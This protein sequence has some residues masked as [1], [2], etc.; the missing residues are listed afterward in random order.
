MGVTLGVTS[1]L[2]VRLAVGLG[3]GV[4][5]GGDGVWLAVKALKPRKRIRKLTNKNVVFFKVGT[6]HDLKQAPAMTSVSRRK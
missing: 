1:P 5:V 4:G 3:E 2:M 6:H